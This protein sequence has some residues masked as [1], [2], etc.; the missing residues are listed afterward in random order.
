MIVTAEEYDNDAD[1][2]TVYHVDE[3]PKQRSGGSQKICRSCYD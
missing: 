3:C 1:D 2:S